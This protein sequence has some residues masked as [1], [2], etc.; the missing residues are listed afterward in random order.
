MSKWAKDPA[1]ERGKWLYGDTGW[2]VFKWAGQ[3]YRIYA[4]D[5]TMSP[6]MTLKAAKE[7]VELKCK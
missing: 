5:K 6:A 4:P 2:M 7:Y 3:G 1:D